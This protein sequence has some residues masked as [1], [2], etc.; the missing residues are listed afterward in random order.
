[1]KNLYV[2]RQTRI[3]QQT[4]ERFERERTLALLLRFSVAVIAFSRRFIDIIFRVT[5]FWFSVREF[6]QKRVCQFER[7]LKRGRFRTEDPQEK[8]N[9]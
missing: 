6:S 4:R 9:K 8:E 5:F 7:G 1:M 3:V 2:C